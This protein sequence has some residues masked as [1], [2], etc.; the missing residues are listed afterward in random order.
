MRIVRA[1][2][3]RRMP[4]KNGGGSTTE[5][6]IAPANATLDNFDWR[7]SM[8][9]MATPG[10]FSRFPGID[11]TLA[12]LEGRGIHLCVADAPAVT[13]TRT[14]LPHIFPGDADTRAALI[15]GPIDDLNAMSRRERYR[16]RMT[17]HRMDATIA[18]PPYA[19]VIAAMP[20]GGSIE[21]VLGATR[22]PIGD[23]ETGIIECADIEHTEIKRA[24]FRP[25]KTHRAEVQT[26][27]Y[28]IGFWRR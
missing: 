13:L 2:D 1:A 6:A 28:L 21:F 19:D 26:V 3:Y 12:I 14:S 18:V 16:H 5:V 10:P 17:H 25:M 23:G 11:R 9:H 8:A 24:V 7:I 22:T 4:W 15:D 20:R 27:L